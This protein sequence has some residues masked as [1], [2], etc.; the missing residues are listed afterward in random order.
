MV[1]ALTNMTSQNAVTDQIVDK[2]KNVFVEPLAENESYGY[3]DYAAVY[4]NP[5]EPTPAFLGRWEGRLQAPTLDDTPAT[6]TFAA[7]GSVSLRIDD[8]APL[9][10]DGLVFNTKRRFQASATG[11]FPPLFADDR[12]TASEATI[13]PNL[14]ETDR[15]LTGYLQIERSG[16]GYSYSVGIFGEF[17]KAED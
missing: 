15:G 1:V 9:T 5:Y 12:G 3:E 11:P 10:L 13:R 14:L 7:D 8:G 4:E 17:K 6:L 16:E 2:I